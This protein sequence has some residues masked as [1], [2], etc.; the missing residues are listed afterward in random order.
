MTLFNARIGIRTSKHWS[1][2][3]FGRNLGAKPF[4]RQTYPT[5]FRSG[6]PGQPGGLWS[7]LDAGSKRLVGSQLQ[8][9]F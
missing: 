1:V 8:A 5:P 3:L 9:K 4:P 7:V 6:A 2:Y